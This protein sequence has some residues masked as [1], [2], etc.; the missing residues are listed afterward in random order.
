[1]KKQKWVTGCKDR[2]EWAE[3]CFMARAKGLGMGVLKPYGD[4]RLYD[5]AVEDGGPIVRVQVKSTIF[6]RRGKEYSLNVMG[7]KRKRYPKGS[8]DFFAVWI[9]PIEEWYIIPVSAMG[10]KLTF[11]ITPGSKRSKWGAYL[12]AWDLLRDTRG[13]RVEIQACAEAEDEEGLGRS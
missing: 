9:I 6:C 4:S 11:H 1:M 8:V 2:G 3:L 12:E 5:V 13:R 10:K 7:P